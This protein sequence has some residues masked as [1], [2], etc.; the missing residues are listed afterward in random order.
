MAS[1]LGSY[2]PRW[3]LSAAQNYADDATDGD[4]N[5]TDA[6]NDSTDDD[7]SDDNTGNDRPMIRMRRAIRTTLTTRARMMTAHTKMRLMTVS[8]TPTGPAR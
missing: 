2:S 3:R 6:D 7:T 8:T 5:S 4:D 1:T